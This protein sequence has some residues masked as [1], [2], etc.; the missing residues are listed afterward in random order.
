MVEMII[1]W[2]LIIFYIFLGMGLL[3]IVLMIINNDWELI[4]GKKTS[5][6]EQDFKRFAENLKKLEKK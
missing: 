6:P 1:S 5:I 3:G 2:I 4:F